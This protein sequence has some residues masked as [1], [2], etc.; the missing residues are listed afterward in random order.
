MNHIFLLCFLKC[1]CYFRFCFMRSY[2]QVIWYLRYSW[3]FNWSSSLNDDNEPIINNSL[4]MLPEGGRWPYRWEKKADITGR[5]C[6]YSIKESAG[7]ELGPSCVFN[8]FTTIV[9]RLRKFSTL[10]VL[11]HIMPFRRSHI[12]IKISNDF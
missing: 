6:V 2:L 12:P 4:K 11:P 3:N 10:Y 7:I 1:Y 8:P 9:P 5:T